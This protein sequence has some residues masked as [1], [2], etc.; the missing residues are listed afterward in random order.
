MIISFMCCL[1]YQRNEFRMS[2][3]II[4]MKINELSSVALSCSPHTCVLSCF[5]PV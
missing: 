4:P 3:S 5:S 2:S 1:H